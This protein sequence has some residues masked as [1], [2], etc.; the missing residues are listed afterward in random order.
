MEIKPNIVV[1]PHCEKSFIHNRVNGLALLE[2]A[3]GVEAKKRMHCRLSLD[4]LER[5]YGGQ[6][7]RPVKKAILDGYNDLARDIHTILGFGT[8]AE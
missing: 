6:L 4:T 3:E 1:C 8:E 7:P 2:I 5:E